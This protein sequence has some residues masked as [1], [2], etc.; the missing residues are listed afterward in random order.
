MYESIEEFKKLIVK[1]ESLKA[2]NY[3]AIENPKFLKV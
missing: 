1:E 2:T 3:I